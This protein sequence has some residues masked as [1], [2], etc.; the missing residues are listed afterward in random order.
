MT[1]MQVS[2]FLSTFMRGPIMD[3]MGLEGATR[4]HSRLSALT[5]LVDAF[6]PSMG[7][8]FLSPFISI[9]QCGEVS[10]DRC[11]QQESARLGLGQGELG[12]AETSMN[13]L[14]SLAMPHVFTTMYT[15][16]AEAA[17]T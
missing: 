3:A 11:L 8:L 4:L 1:C 7:Y 10:M 2:M 16:L 9:A 17:P 14:P 5:C 12:A 6:S 15:T 13:F